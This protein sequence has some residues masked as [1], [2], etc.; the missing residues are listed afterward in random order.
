LA[1]FRRNKDT[2]ALT[3]AGTLNDDEFGKDGLDGASGVAV[4]SD[5]EHVY[6]ASDGDDAVAVFEWDEFMGLPVL[7]YVEFKKDG[8]GDVNGL[9]GARAVAVSSDG[10]HVYVVGRD[11]D[12]LVDFTRSALTGRLT[13]HKGWWDDG[14]GIDG[15]DTP[16]SV[17]VHPFNNEIY[18]TGYGDQALAV[19]E[20]DPVSGEPVYLGMEQHGVNGVEGMLGPWAVT[21]SPDGRH[22]YVAGIGN[23]AV[24]VFARSVIHLPLVIRS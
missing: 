4:S 1:Y 15:L 10:E 17:A 5:G 21:V 20:R 8:V 7:S 9:N 3:W 23:D 18:A 2:G 12:A 24:V 14:G 16:R 6:V 19:F 11:E 13:Y 22:L